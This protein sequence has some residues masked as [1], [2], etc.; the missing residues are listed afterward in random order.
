MP[1]PGEIISLVDRIIDAFAPQNIV[2]FGSYANGMPTRD[3]DVDLLV[4]MR[5]HGPSYQAASRIRIAVDVNFPL[6]VLVRSPAEI[7]RRLRLRDMF[8]SEILQ[9]GIILHDDHDRRVGAQ[10]R[11]RL[12]HRLHPSAIT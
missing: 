12:R 9:E 3:S 2:L 10:G 7:Q 1:Q 6:D 11:R 5:H 4:V 8:I